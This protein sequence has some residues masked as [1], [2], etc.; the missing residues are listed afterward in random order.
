MELGFH[1][2]TFPNANVAEELH[3]VRHRPLRKEGQRAVGQESQL[4]SCLGMLVE[5]LRRDRYCKSL[6]KYYVVYEEADEELSEDE[7]RH[8]QQDDEARPHPS[9]CCLCDLR[10]PTPALT[11]NAWALI[12][13]SP[14]GSLR[15]RRP[16][17]RPTR[18]PRTASL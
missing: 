11:S 4:V 3:Q 1:G 18:L 15:R 17:S 16:Q 5:T 9:P 10:Q 6:F 8:E 2:S 13:S 7:E 12:E 14:E